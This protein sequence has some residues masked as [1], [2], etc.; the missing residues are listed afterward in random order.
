[1]KITFE[2]GRKGQHSV[3]KQNEML[4]VTVQELAKQLSEERAGHATTKEQLRD[5]LNDR[6][7]KGHQMRKALTVINGGQARF[8]LEG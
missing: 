8:Q 4:L 7:V 5:A 3:R 6:V 2:F 1:M